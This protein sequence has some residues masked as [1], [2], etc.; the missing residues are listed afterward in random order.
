MEGCQRFRCAVAA[1]VMSDE[2]DM[3]ARGASVWPSSLTIYYPSSSTLPPSVREA[4][5]LT[6]PFCVNSLIRETLTCRSPPL[7]LFILVGKYFIDFCSNRRRAEMRRALCGIRLCGGFPEWVGSYECGCGE[8]GNVPARNP[9]YPFSPSGWTNY[10]CD[11][12]TIIAHPFLLVTIVYSA[13]AA[14][15]RFA[16]LLYRYANSSS[17]IWIWHHV[18]SCSPEQECD[19]KLSCFHN[20][21][22]PRACEM[23]FCNQHMPNSEVTL[24]WVVISAV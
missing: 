1:K 22:K 2:V 10:S 14:S 21:T 12:Q 16:L 24:T 11:P 13:P 23:F 8:G 4:R 5:K 7:F 18:S 17:K 9:Y 3:R 6:E 15:P 19:G 20:Q